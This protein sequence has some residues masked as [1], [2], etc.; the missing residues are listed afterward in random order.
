MSEIEN[1]IK[2]QGYTSWALNT[3]QR[4]LKHR[5]AEAVTDDNIERQLRLA[6]F[7][8]QLSEVRKEEAVGASKYMLALDDL[9]AGATVPLPLVYLLETRKRFPKLF[10]ISSRS[11]KVASCLSRLDDINE[12]IEQEDQPYFVALRLERFVLNRRLSQFGIAP[13][14]RRLSDHLNFEGALR[15]ELHHDNCLID[16]EWMN[17]RRN[18]DWLPRSE[19]RSHNINNRNWKSLLEEFDLLIASSVISSKYGK[20]KKLKQLGLFNLPLR[21][22]LVALLSAADRKARRVMH[23]KLENAKSKLEKA[24]EDI[25]QIRESELDRRLI[26]LHAAAL[27]NW[28]A[29]RAA[30]YVRMMTG[31]DVTQ[32]STS[33]MLKKLEA[34]PGIR[35]K[36]LSYPQ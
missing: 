36:S 6:R 32:Q 29:S 26:Y 28:S 23:D 13:R 25:G 9:S 10:P 20:H 22:E 19:I 17:S 4:E 16:L 8:A 27:S 34:V 1:K 24:S 2:L 3:L 18:L 11:M 30:R 15:H 7:L 12:G 5:F 33:E 14:W 21:H 31:D 35:K